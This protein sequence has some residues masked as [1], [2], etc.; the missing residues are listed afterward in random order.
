MRFSVITITFNAEQFLAQTLESVA[1]Q[2]GVDYE[3]LIWDGGSNDR[4]LEIAHSF[5]HVKIIEGRDSGI[6]DAMNRGAA[7]AQGEFIIHLH[8]DDA[9]SH[10]RALLMMNRALLLHP[11]IEWLYGQANIINEKGSRLRTTRYEP[12]SGKR[13]RKY[14]FI[15]HPATVVS[16]SL[17]KRVGGFC[18]D[19]R[20]YMDY[21]L[22]LRL[23]RLSTPFALPAILASFREHNGSLSTREPFQVADEAYH[24]R[25]RYVTSLYER[26]RSFR[27][28]KKRKAPPI[29]SKY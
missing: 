9:L 28:W 23:A 11:H 3:H 26:F 2:E 5:N 27:T 24:V 18:T 10:P 22:W 1:M 13:L 12:F 16:Y 6:A 17:F 21:D 29:M 20:Y 25:N 7:H 4:T 14:N 8:A 15:T 19:L